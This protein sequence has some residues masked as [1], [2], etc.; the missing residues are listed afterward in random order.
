M[1][2]KKMQKIVIFL[3]LFAMLATSLLA[4]LSFLF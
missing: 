3:M 4:G 2:N 1:S